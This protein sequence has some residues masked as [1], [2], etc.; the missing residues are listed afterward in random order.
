MSERFQTFLTRLR[1]HRIAVLV[2]VNDS[3]WRK[4]CLG[5]I[6]YLSQIWGGYNSL[7]VLTDGQSIETAFWE[8]LSA[9]DADHIFYYE[10]T[11]HDQQRDDP[12]EVEKIIEEAYQELLSKG[13]EHDRDAFR[14]TWMRK[15]LDNFSISQDLLHE[16]F[17]RLNPFH[18]QPMLHIP[19]IHLGQNVAMPFTKVAN[20]VRSIEAPDAIC[21]LTNNLPADRTAP[22]P[23]WFAAEHGAISQRFQEDLQI[24]GVTVAPQFMNVVSDEKIISAG[25]NWEMPWASHT[26]FAFSRLSLIGVRSIF[27]RPH[28]HAGIVVC[29]ETLKDFCLCYAMSRLLGRALWLPKWFLPD[30]EELPEMTVE[31]LKQ[32][33]ALVKPDHSDTLALISAS[34][35]SS[36]LHKII[37]KAGTKLPDIPMHPEDPAQA[38]FMQPLLKYPVRLY[39]RRNIE[40]VTTHQLVDD[41]LPGYFES[42]IPEA[43]TEINAH[44]HR[45][46]VELAFAGSQFPR[47]TA[48]NNH[49]TPNTPHTSC[50]AAVDGFAYHCPGPYVTFGDIE[51]QSIRLS[52]TVPTPEATFNT[53]LKAG[54][55]DSQISDKGSYQSESV[56]KFGDLGKIVEVF[57][58]DKKWALL[59]KFRDMSRNQPGIHDQGCLLTDERRYLDFTPMLNILGDKDRVAALID[60]WIA[61][62]ILYRGFIFKCARCGNTSWFSVESLTQS[63][64]CSRCGTSQQY[65][66]KNWF[67]TPEPTWYYKLDEI[68]HLLLEHNGD[69]PLRTL[70]ALKYQFSS[71]FIY[72]PELKIKATHK[73]Q[74]NMELDICC[75]GDGQIIIGEAKSND[76]L[77]ANKNPDK[78]VK[79]YRYIAQKMRASALIFSTSQPKWDEPSEKAIKELRERDPFFRV[80]SYTAQTLKPPPKI[81]TPFPPQT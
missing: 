50:R 54:G 6:E 28:F 70:A 48:L 47:H 25:I 16:I 36:D 81:A 27:A 57:H 19:H 22:P 72:V 78:V 53:I 24:M 60:D 71:S 10:K 63:F 51:L 58:D 37:W 17:D 74:D 26:P 29:G 20:I 14:I 33:F 3:D 21:P 77:K 4:T 43:L 44:L 42:P 61:R 56:S 35:S 39:I 59:Q 52:V 46:I 69:V 13:L 7:I 45:W 9:F 30:G 62:E 66:K 55:Y 49:V 79:K 80:Y 1:T 23:L 76:S 18:Y 15:R 41:K 38:Y 5:I 32:F 73:P 2:D 65:S 34:L 31:A 40:R 64:R 8:I 12:L 11:L 67:D 75:I 68:V